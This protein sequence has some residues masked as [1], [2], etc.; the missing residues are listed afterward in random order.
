M[1]GSVTDYF[2]QLMLGWSIQLV[3]AFAPGPSVALIASIALSEG[4]LPALRTAAGVAGGSIILASAT[5]LGITAL[6]AELSELM[7]LVRIAGVLYLAWLA[8]KAFKNA[9]HPPEFVVSQQASKNRR[10]P[11]LR[12]F[13]LQISNPKAILFWLAIA[14][15]AH[16]GDVSLSYKA[17]FVAVA[18]AISFTAH[19][20][21]GILLSIGPI[22][23]AY[24]RARRWIEGAFGC[25]FMFASY[26]LATAKL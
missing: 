2:P 7:S 20:A 4:R 1:I 16:V 13:M 12:G 3:G 19:G 5:V 17:L 24:R 25:F 6:F 11:A 10:H 23:L 18:F 22:R 26:T 14:T 21:Y 9:A 15:V 8:F